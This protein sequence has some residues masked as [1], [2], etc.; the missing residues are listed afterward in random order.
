M[1]GLFGISA[2]QQTNKTWNSNTQTQGVKAGTAAKAEQANAAGKSTAAKFEAKEWSPIDTTSA[3]VPRNTEYGFAIGD[4]KLSDEAKE[5]YKE[6]KSKYHNMEF[7]AVSKDMKAQ[8]QQNA[9]AY[10]NSG[11]MVVLID[12]EKL[13]RMA[14]DESFRKKYEGI[15]S[16]AQNQ[17]TAAKNDL[18]GSGAEVKNFGMSVDGNGKIKY[19]ASLEKN[20]AAQKK[21]IEK[22]A[23]ENR[24][25]KIKENKA[26]KKEQLEKIKNK[27]AEKTDAEET[28]IAEETEDTEYVTFEADS[29]EELLDKVTK[30]SYE[31]ASSR[32]FTET[33]LSRGTQV[34]YM[35]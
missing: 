27:N 9:A 3:L 20:S 15:I 13:E 17:L 22:K 2:Y 35:G 1:S 28:E 4:V 18:A 21:R 5:Y 24:A 16:M 34:D 33:E 31:G 8:V 32:V 23:A 25:K 26:A 14:T 11:K 10:G 6:L 19:F 12:D 29:L 7:I 30:Y